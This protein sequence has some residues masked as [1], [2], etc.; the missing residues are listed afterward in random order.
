M[1]IVLKLCLTKFWIYSNLFNNLVFNIYFPIFQN[2]IFADLIPQN[3]KTKREDASS[4]FINIGPYEL[5]KPEEALSPE[6]LFIV[7]LVVILRYWQTFYYLLTGR[8][9]GLSYLRLSHLIQLNRAYV[10]KT[11]FDGR[12]KQHNTSRTV[13]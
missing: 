3:K 1:M 10:A 8:N 2:I 12:V 9:V 7:P 11:F 4:S 6:I 5:F 13:K